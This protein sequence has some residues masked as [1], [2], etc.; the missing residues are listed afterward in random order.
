M[1]KYDN[2][3]GAPGELNGLRAFGAGP[4]LT[5]VIP[6]YNRAPVLAKCLDAL[7]R[8]TC[9]PN[10][11]EVAVADDGSSDAT[12]ETTQQV[13][14]LRLPRIRYLF[15]QNSG[16]NTAR[17][18][19]IAAAKS[20][21]LLLIN[22]DVIPTPTM[23]AEHLAMHAR[24]P[25][26]RVAVL[27][28]VTVSPHLPPSRLAAL[29]LDRA[30]SNLGGQRELDWHAFFTCNV[31]VKKSLLERGGMFEEGIRYHEDLE[32]GERL[33]HHGL[34]VIYCPEALGY[35]DHFLGE[36]EFFRTAE[37]EAKA[38]AVW[39]RKAPHLMPLLAPLGFEP[40]MALHR[41]IRRRLLAMAVNKATIPLWRKVAR[42]CPSQL[43][44]VSL[45]IYGTIYKAVMRSHLLHQL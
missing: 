45:A 23:L 26:D 8:Q 13:S 25:D 32:L 34:R 6:T 17:N 41:R 16:A 15:Q 33:S 29:H 44:P 7:C 5:V 20:P 14:E 1:T 11:Y 12:R 30:Y 21:I 3:S 9:A 40:A 24:Y 37:K 38:L 2:D 43:D 4:L 31:S 39:A 36:E 35:H 22:D 10:L 42:C 19:A 27:G 28:R 18:R